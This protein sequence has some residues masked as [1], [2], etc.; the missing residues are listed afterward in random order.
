MYEKS[1]LYTGWNKTLVTGL[2]WPV[3]EYLLQKKKINIKEL[4]EILNLFLNKRE[5]TSERM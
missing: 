5:T 3:K 4:P 1:Y 2:R